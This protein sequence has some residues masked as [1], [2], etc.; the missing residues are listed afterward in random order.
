MKNKVKKGYMEQRDMDKEIT[1]KTF[2]AAVAY[3]G[4][5]GAGMVGGLI[6]TAILPGIGT[7][8]G[9]GLGFY[10]G[11]FAGTF[12]GTFLGSKVYKL[13]SSK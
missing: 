13:F 3:T 9:G 2:G 4:I 1:K 6:G 7:A 11:N 8:V 12:G 5:A 10:I